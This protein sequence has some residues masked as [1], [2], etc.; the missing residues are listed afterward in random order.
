MKVKKSIKKPADWYYKVVA[1]KKNPSKIDI[2]NAGYNYFRSG[3]YD[4]AISHI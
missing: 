1:I 2:Y 4:N 3:N